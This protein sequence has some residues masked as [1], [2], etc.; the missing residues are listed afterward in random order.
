MPPMNDDL[1]RSVSAYIKAW[2]YMGG[3]YAVISLVLRVTL[4]VGS[5]LVAAK[6][7]TG[8]EKY[9]NDWWTATVSIYVA[10]GTALESWLKPRE[11][12]KGFM[13]DREK[14]EDL[15]MR[16]DNT[17]PSDLKRVEEL[18]AELQRIIATHREKNVF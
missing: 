16:L 4:I 6:V 15:F 13:T 11:K 14:A 9:L 17:D 12:W 8:T 3:V 5:A 18:R 7:A 2:H 1:K 10:A